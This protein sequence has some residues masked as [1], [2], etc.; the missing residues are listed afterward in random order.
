MFKYLLRYQ[1]MGAACE[2][3]RWI[4][5]K[6][7]LNQANSGGAN[8]YGSFDGLFLNAYLTWCLVGDE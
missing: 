6:N 3:S 7:Q 4:N 8:N 5:Q 2:A 1:G